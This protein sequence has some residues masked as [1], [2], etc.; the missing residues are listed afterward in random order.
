MKFILNIEDFNEIVK[1]IKAMKAD[2]VYVNGGMLFGTDNNFTILKTYTIDTIIPIDPF[3]I[4][5]KTL[6]SEFFNNI[7]D[8]YIT[9]D[10]D[11]NKIYCPGNE[12]RF[13]D[14]PDMINTYY[15]YKI[16]SIINNLY[17]DINSPMTKIIEFGDITNDEN[18]QRFKT[19]KSAE[20]ADLY[21]PCGNT[22]YGMFLYSG[23]IP[24]AKADKVS[25][26]E[27]DLGNVFISH[28]TILK[29]KLNPIN[30]YIRYVKLEKNMYRA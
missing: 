22:T 4:I 3:T 7:T 9:I 6:S 18:F 1:G 16:E 27:Y 25:L 12:S 20:G 2:L 23:A 5:T 15:N 21:I 8:V 26:C 28:F 17:R 11:S 10:T 19:I 29:K 14:Y 24:M 13:I 30:L